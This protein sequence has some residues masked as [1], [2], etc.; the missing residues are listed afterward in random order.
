MYRWALAFLLALCAIAPAQTQWVASERH[1]DEVRF[2][3]GDRIRRYDLHTQSWLGVFTLPRTNAVA[4]AADAEG[5]VVAYGSS[6]Y[7]YDGAFAGESL[8]GSTSSAI[9]SVFL[10]GNLVIAVHSTGSYGRVTVFNRTT[11]SVLSS[12]NTYVDSIHGASHAKESNRLY[13]RTQGRSPSDILTASYTDAGIVT[14]PSDSPYHG[15]YASAS[16][17][18]IFPG[19]TRVVDS[20]GTVY[21]TPGLSYHGSF[22]GTLTDIAFN[23]D[24]PVVLRGNEVVSFTHTLL[25]AG[26]ASVSAT[27]N[28][29]L[30]VTASE[31]YVF[32]PANADPFVEVIALSAIKAPEPG[33]PVNPE[34]LAYTVD[35][36]FT[37]KD[38]NLLLFSKAQMSL[39][40]WSPS[41]RKY[42][43]SFALI[44]APLYAA[45]SKE[46]HAA[47]FAYENQMVRKMD[48]SA[49][50]PKETP[51]FNLP[52]V[53]R[54]LAT[55]GSYVF[56]SDPSGAWASHYIHAADGTMTDSLD[57]NYYSR[58]WEWDP[59]KRR[60][61]FFRDDTS[62]NDLHFETIDEAGEIV[63][64]GETPYH[65]D[66]STVPPIRVSPDGSRVIIGSGVAFQTDGMTKTA[67]LANNFSDAVWR[68]DKLFTIRLI[69]G[70]TQLQ[71]WEGPQLLPGSTIRQFSGTPVRLLDTTAGLL[72]ITSVEGTPRF[73]LLNARFKTLFMSPTKP[74]APADLALVARTV[75]SVSLSWADMSDNEDGFRVEYLD[76]Q[77]AW[78]KAATVR[79]GVTRAKVGKL[80]PMTAYRFRVVA[81]AKTLVSIASNEVPARTLSSPKQPPG[82]P[83]FL[84]VSRIFSDRVT[85]EWQDNATIESGFLI[86]RSTSPS[87]LGTELPAP[88]NATS[89]TDSGLEASTTY[90]YRVQ[91]ARGEIIGD[92]S[93]QVSATTGYG[94]YRPGAPGSLTAVMDGNSAVHLTWK[95]NSMNEEE[96]IIERSSSPA[97]TWAEAGR[98]G[99]NVTSFTDTTVS[100]GTSYSYRVKASN[101]TGNNTSYTV[102]ITTPKLGGEFAGHAIRSGEIY[103]FTFKSP[104]RIERYNLARRS[105]LKP[106]LLEAEPSALWAD[107]SGIFV[108]EDRAVVRYKLDGKGRTALANG[109]SKVTAL[110]TT[111]NVLVFNSSYDGFTTLNKLNGNFLSTFDYWYQGSGYSSAPGSNRVFFRSTSVSP[112]DIHFLEIAAD[113]TLS[114]GV[115]SPYHGDYGH[116]TRTFVFPNGARVADD[117][118]TIYSTDSLSYN[119]TFGGAFTDLSFHGQ[120][121]P[122]VLRQ[123]KLVS[124]SNTLLEAGSFDLGATGLRM[125]VNRQ[126]AIVFF[127]DGSSQRGLRVQIVPLSTLSAP[128][129]GAEIDPKGL[130]FT[131]DEVFMDKNG[132]ILLF[133]KA[134]LSLFRWSPETKQYTATYP[135]LGAPKYAAYSKENHAAY[136]AYDSQIVRKMD[137]S[138]AKPA[139]IPLFNLP[140]TPRG[141]ATAG[142]FVFASDPSGAWG[143]HYL[144]SADGTLTDSVDWNYYSTVWE[145][146]PVQGR[147]YFFRD[148]SS[149]NDL[150]FETIDNLGKITGEGETPYHGDFSAQKPIRVSPDGSRVVIGSGVVFNAT[151]MSKVASLGN[152]FTDAGWFGDRLVTARPINGITQLQTWSGTQFV[153]GPEVR[154]FTGTPL[155]LLVLD[156]SRLLLISL[157]DGVPRY[158]ILNESLEATYISPT[159]PAPPADLA[160]AG[161]GVS[162][163]N[164]SW[165][166]GSDNEDGFRIEYRTAGGAWSS[167]G[168]AAANATTEIITGLALGTTYEFRVVA[169]LGDLSSSPTSSVSATTLTSPD[170]P[171][172]EPYGLKITRVF[173]NS[174]TLEWTDNATN[175]T[176]FRI[177]LSTAADGPATMLAVPA[178]TITFTAADLLPNSQYYFRVQ[179]VNGALT[180]DLSAQVND[181][182]LSTATAPATPTSLVVASKTANSVTLVWKDNARNEDNYLVERSDSAA[183]VW[184]Q[185]GSLPFNSTTFTDATVAANTTYG[186]RVKA[187]NATG[188]TTSSVVKVTTPKLGGDF[189]GQ[190]LRAGDV[191]YFIFNSPN[192][193][194]RYDLNSRAWLPPVPLQ[195]TGSALW[196]DEAGIF[197]SEDRAVIRFA[198]DGSA[199]TPMGNSQYTVRSL[200]TSGDLLVFNSGDREFTTL[201]KLNGNFLSTFDYWYAGVG[202]SSAPALNRTFFRSSGVSPSDIHYLEIGADGKLIKGNQS[203]YHGDYPGATRTFVFP[204]GARVADDSGTVYST[205]SLSFTNSFGGSFTDLSFHGQDIPILLRGNKLHSY[206]NALLEAGSHILPATGLRM[207]V[208]QQDAIVFFADGSNDHGLGVQA[209]PL[210]LLSAPVPGQ[211]VDPRG[212]AFTPDD[213]FLDKDGEILLFS[214]SQ[215]SLFRWSPTSKDYLPTYPLVGSPSFSGY[216]KETHR[217]Y[218]AYENQTVRMMDLSAAAPAEVPLFSLSGTPRGFAMAGEFPYAGTTNNLSTYTSTGTLIGSSGFTYYMGSHNTWDP[219]NRRMYHFRDGLSPNDLHYDI[220]GLNGAI[221]GGGESPYHGDFTVLKPIRV[222][223]EGTHIAIG[224]GAIFSATGLTRLTT[225]SGGFVDSLWRPTEL[226]TIH[227]SGTGQTLLK[228]WNRSGFTTGATVPLFTGTPLRLLELDSQRLLLITLDRGMPRFYLL[229]ADLSVAYDYVPGASGGALSTASPA[230]RSGASVSSDSSA[231]AALP[232]GNAIAAAATGAEPFAIKRIARQEDGSMLLEFTTM[233]GGRYQMEYSSDGLTW[234]PCSL[235]IEAVGTT[236]EWIDLGAPWT[237]CEPSRASRRFYRA[238]TLDD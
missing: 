187:T 148:D 109:E 64:E 169:T 78:V 190:S 61:Y 233:P 26:R 185:I 183:V 153:A 213:V 15:D 219:V 170:Q 63:G 199:R 131:P 188:T 31:A 114:K 59:A 16:K 167:G 231:A 230:E 81:T 94:F 107:G 215:L 189:A 202:F 191:Y 220:I 80:K 48:L 32:T 193:I 197:V 2:L 41:S 55:A 18:W 113:G 216:S 126:D 21:N 72:L 201:N 100:P 53:P 226:L 35:N 171:V 124:Y 127:N 174:M 162:T 176:G 25:E 146:D 143:T 30:Q 138:P 180:G 136:F 44:G 158:T 17:T 42:T 102:T 65:G 11:G 37:D 90:Y 98:V 186:Y 5:A 91:I 151:G 134:Q 236:A 152:A 182:T 19:E 211:A 118:G 205:D 69:N 117:S 221:T 160:V 110:F 159:K 14:G 139:E 12:I 1:G 36:V 200:F 129:P 173:Q 73:T 67:S 58:V 75:N 60:M 198:L 24:V 43:G 70:I 163:V 204:N 50:E 137:L 62:P 179:A 150:H 23:G 45:Y 79:A 86:Y 116:A 223:P 34:G 108:A 22:A 207:A 225:L 83:Y 123:T 121:I 28:S 237:E 154:Q 111:G 135:L 209:V 56:A 3:Y 46:N 208:N 97:T 228:R 119:H 232:Q 177:L 164:L 7:R 238:R 132:E 192:R 161:R 142:S 144:F 39:F 184:T 115:E 125:A 105:W 122:I 101:A 227:A 103:Y 203:P 9:Q 165:T 206:S 155:R 178:G 71:T 140:G 195:S 145:W 54:G 8:V 128:V 74:V 27:A 175:E 76:D 181:R 156:S 10:D 224:S 196:V 29:E 133:S 33:S 77:G 147:M 4:M 172:G 88:A 68:G 112:S 194:E 130:A 92:L 66:F 6:V 51:F 234:E 82:E 212:L 166:D 149:P 214:K 168:T 49:P 210:D 120:D 222:S 84:R 229:N 93:G 85:L 47:Y 38:G 104:N 40:R 20:S 87:E 141:L 95:D 157:V 96:F 99:Y 106:I 217:A 57:W 235:P 13:G 218:F 52:G 89:F